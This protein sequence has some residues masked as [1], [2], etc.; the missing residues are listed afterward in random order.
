[1]LR[2][3]RQGYDEKMWTIGY[4]RAPKIFAHNFG[5]STQALGRLKPFVT[6]GTRVCMVLAQLVQTV[7]KVLVRRRS[8]LDPP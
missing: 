6:I 2:S 4:A 1:M 3:E 5:M 7:G 8:L